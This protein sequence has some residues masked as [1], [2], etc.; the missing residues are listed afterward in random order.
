MPYKIEVTGENIQAVFQDV[1]NLAIV[2]GQG[3]NNAFRPP[4]TAPAEV[5]VVQSVQTE[6]VNT[7]KN[8]PV[9]PL[10]AEKRKPGRP[11]EVQVVEATATEVKNHEAEVVKASTSDLKNFV[12][13][14]SPPAEI[15]TA[16]TL[17]LKEDI[18]PRV[19][20][21]MDGWKA[22]AE[23]G[24]AENVVTQGGVNYAVGLLAKFGAKSTKD[25][26]PEQFA[27]FMK[28]SEAYLDGS[29]K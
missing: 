17:T 24:T 14:A 6:G 15:E 28:A 8:P 25:L 21:I 7:G 4:A 18:Q 23:P 29:A 3:G 2:F 1:M 11:P 5:P 9:A 19:R 16:K 20:A 22:R 10:S 26:K 27:D 13:E 12:L